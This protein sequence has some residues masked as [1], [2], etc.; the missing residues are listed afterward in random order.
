MTTQLEQ[1]SALLQLVADEGIEALDVTSGQLSL[2]VRRQAGTA[3][4]AEVVSAPVDATGSAPA[5]QASGAGAGSADMVEVSAP[6]DGVFYRSATAGGLPLCEQ[7]ARVTAGSVLG[8]IESMK[9]M[10]EITAPQGGIV[11]AVLSADGAAVS[12]G[13]P[14]FIIEKG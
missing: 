12:S 14:L 11:R 3:V 6:V 2:S 1:I 7:G 9:I 4:V 5:V 10:N 13:K 8:I